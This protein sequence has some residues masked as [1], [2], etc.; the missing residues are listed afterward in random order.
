LI[1]AVHCIDAQLG[2][3]NNL[4]LHVLSGENLAITVLIYIDVVTHTVHSHK[5]GCLKHR[6]RPIEGAAFSVRNVTTTVTLAKKLAVAL[7][8]FL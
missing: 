4:A 8:I 6:S 1:T 3:T 7:N 5:V 2:K